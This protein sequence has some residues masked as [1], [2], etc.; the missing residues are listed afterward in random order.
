LNRARLSNAAAVFV[1]PDI[2]ATARYYRE[3]FGFTVVEHYDAEEAFATIYRDSVEVVLV[4]ARGGEVE[5]N[6]ARYGAGFDI[7]FDPD[8]LEGVDALHAELRAK[9]ARILGQPAMTPYG[10]YEFVVEDVDGRLIGIGRISDRE[11]F[12]RAPS[13]DGSGRGPAGPAAVR[14]RPAFSPPGSQ[15]ARSM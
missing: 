7:Y 11:T 12:F 4:E 2:R 6:R 5:S 9:G 8:T 3:V 15:S 1:T 13:A 14:R 10:S